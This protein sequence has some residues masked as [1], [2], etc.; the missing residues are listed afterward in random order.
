MNRKNS[1]GAENLK[2]DIYDLILD[3]VQLPNN[4]T[5]GRLF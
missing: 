1:P 3:N 4:R 2:E 5:I